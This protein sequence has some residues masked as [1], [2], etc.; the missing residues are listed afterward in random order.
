MSRFFRQLMRARMF[1]HP[2][3]AMLVHFP[4]ALFPVSLALDVLARLSGGSS[5]AVAA[6]YAIAGGLLGGAAA[7]VFGAMDYFRLPATHAAWKK[8]SLH[9]LLNFVWLMWFGVLFGLRLKQYPQIESATTIEI[10]LSGVA[11]A[12]LL[13]SNFLGGELVFRHKLGVIEKDSTST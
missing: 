9:A 3:H 6:F 10:I 4:S 7:A 5:F 13:F 12:G 2:I 1:G 11:V 8:A